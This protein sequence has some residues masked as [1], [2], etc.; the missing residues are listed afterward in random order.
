M[1]LNW[2]RSAKVLWF[3]NLATVS[4]SIKFTELFACVPAE[5]GKYCMPSKHRYMSV[6]A[7]WSSSPAKVFFFLIENEK[8]GKGGN[9]NK[10]SKH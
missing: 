6:V 3:W 2:E 8:K 9:E 5:V 7:G 4:K 1:N 10:N